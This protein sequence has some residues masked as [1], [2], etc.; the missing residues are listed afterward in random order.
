MGIVS[1]RIVG[2]DSGVELKAIAG[3]L[4]SSEPS[5]YL[6]MPTA[7]ADVLEKSSVGDTCYHLAQRDGIAL[8]YIYSGPQPFDEKEIK[9]YHFAL[10]TQLTEPDAAFFVAESLFDTVQAHWELRNFRNTPGSLTLSCFAR[11]PSPGAKKLLEGLDY[12]QEGPDNWVKHCKK[13]EY[14]RIKYIGGA[15]YPVPLTPS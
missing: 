4:Q 1:I 7:L 12:S 5:R 8:G 11:D 14:P 9:I 2:K 10:S 3:I 6:D 15:Q 13:V